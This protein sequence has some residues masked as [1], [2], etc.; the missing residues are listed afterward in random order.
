MQYS[1][2]KLPRLQNSLPTTRLQRLAAQRPSHLQIQ[3]R[4]AAGPQSL[5][6]QHVCAVQV[7]LLLIALRFASRKHSPS[8]VPLSTFRKMPGTDQQEADREESRP[9]TTLFN[10]R[11]AHLLCEVCICWDK[12]AT[13]LPMATA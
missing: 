11:S 9:V 7:C 2:L 12:R 4:S 5:A 3:R 6:T 13:V 8:R 10:S 1:L